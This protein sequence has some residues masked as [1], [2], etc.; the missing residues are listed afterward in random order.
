MSF[1]ARELAKRVELQDYVS[2]QD[3]ETG[4]ITRTWTTFAT[5]MAKVEPLV[6][7]EY[8]AAAA[9][10]AENTV[11]FTMRYQ[12]DLRPHHRLLYDGKLWNIQSVINPKGRNRETLV[13]AKDI[14][15][16]TI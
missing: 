6:G 12:P 1:T 11:K 2:T 8:F 15:E 9:I 7:R 16:G 13:M 5:V 10:Q 14:A 3:P 4:Y